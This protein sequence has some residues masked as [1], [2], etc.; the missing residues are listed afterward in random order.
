[1]MTLKKKSNDKDDD[2]IKSI[3]CTL[4]FDLA[5]LMP[6]VAQLGDCFA[7]VLISNSINTSPEFFIDFKFTQYLI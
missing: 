5:E 7:F 1:M 6:T 4:S 2:K 3:K